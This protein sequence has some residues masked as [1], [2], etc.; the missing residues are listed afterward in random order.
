MRSSSSGPIA[1][2]LM[3]IPLCIV[4][5]LAFFGVPQVHP[6]SASPDV[7][8]GSESK[9]GS[10]GRNAADDGFAPID[11][12]DGG[13][14]NS[15]Q[16]LSNAPAGDSADTPAPAFQNASGKNSDQ[17]LPAD[18][19]NGE[20]AGGDPPAAALAGWRLE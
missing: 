2:F 10:A 1:T 16:F 5:L 15:R 4:P 19:Q 11:T 9:S 12:H 17:G 6:L 20:G 7:E 18:V 3:L 13:G 14:Q 8:L